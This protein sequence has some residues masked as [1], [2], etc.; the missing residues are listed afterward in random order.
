MKPCPSTGQL[1]ELLEERLPA[2]EQETVAAHV[3]ECV[4]CQGRLDVLDAD[5][6]EAR[7]RQLRQEA[8]ADCSPVDRDMLLEI[9]DHLLQYAQLLEAQRKR[10]K[11][12]GLVFPGAQP[13]QGLLGQLGCYRV[14]KELGCGATGAVFLAHDERLNRQVVLKVL[15]PSLAALEHSR[16]RF[17]REGRAAAAIHHDH[18]VRVHHVGAPEPNFPWPYLVMEFIDGETLTER[19]ARDKQL[20]PREAAAI[21]RQVTEGMAQAHEQR[22]VHRDVKSPNILLERLSGR[23]KLTDFG[24]AGVLD[25]LD[26]KTRTRLTRESQVFGTPGYMSPE[27]ILSPQ[28]VGPPSD[29]YSL[30]VVLYEMLAGQ[31]PFSGPSYHLLLQRVLHDEP[32]LPSHSNPMVPR[33]LDTISMQCLHKDPRRRYPSA[34]E[35]ADDLQRFLEHQ[36]IHA[37]PVGWCERTWKLAR[38]H[39]LL[40]LALGGILASLVIAVWQWQAAEAARS[41]AEGALD[42]ADANLYFTNVALADSKWRDTLLVQA[43]QFLD[44]CPAAHRHWEWHHLQ[45]RLNGQLMTLEGHH[46]RVV[47][48]AF[49]P[50]GRWLA[51]GGDGSGAVLWDSRTG[52]AVRVLAGHTGS[53][54][55]VAFSS[56]GTLLATAASDRSVRVWDRATGKERHR[57]AGHAGWVQSLAFH[58]REPWL[59]WSWGEKAATVW[60]VVS[61]AEIWRVPSG[62][63]AVNSVAFGPDGQTLALACGEQGKGELTIWDVRTRRRVQSFPCE[64]HGFQ[65]LAFNADGQRLAAGCLIRDHRLHEPGMIHVWDTSRGTTIKTLR[66]PVGPTNAVAFNPDGRSLATIGNRHLR[67]WNLE[68]GEEELLHRGR[69][70]L[71]CLAFHPEGHQVAWGGDEPGIKVSSALS[72]PAVQTF[73]IGQ[74]H[75][76]N[77]VALHPGGTQIAAGFADEQIRFWDLSTGRL[78]HTCTH[79]GTWRGVVSV[80]FSP[81]GEWLASASRGQEVK[82]WHVASGKEKAELPHPG[83]HAV[84]FGCDGRLMASGGTDRRVCI[85]EVSSRREIMVLQGHESAVLCLAF[86]PDGRYLASGSADY[87]V[88]LWNA[89]TGALVAVLRGDALD[90]N[91]VA[92][93]RD[94]TLLASASS[95]HLIRLYDLPSGREVRRCQGHAFKACGVAFSPDGKRIASTSDDKTVRIWETNTGREILTLT[96]HKGG[97]TS[98]VFNADGHKLATGSWDGT[99]KVFDGTPR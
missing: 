27:Q 30:G 56:D 36:P 37:R 24:L 96:A 32:A 9:R 39:P 87:S 18:V 99:V 34:R 57:F 70:A 55:A 26:D 28:Q 64:E 50:D 14:V 65:S 91:G 89:A 25:D 45:R 80:C 43:G 98:V 1:Q 58:P 61:G 31:L 20:P 67:L 19:L 72:E 38:R 47:T 95:D 3:R 6:T 12:S 21:A 13:D 46:T 90:I 41:R 59:A 49:S 2:T 60:D 69:V 77:D 83:V 33:D 7:W 17:E 66:A 92:F 22:L 63:H 79:K 82:L 35:L 48:L 10:D 44:D 78:L 23:A 73:R 4:V 93:N 51:S 15:L 88:R 75:V 42:R 86:S 11:T 74:R 81:D 40:A 68:T 8:Q 5:E 71:L 53:V 76:A 84:T 52:Q 94:S 62:R 54:V 16:A 29:V 97:T 85:W